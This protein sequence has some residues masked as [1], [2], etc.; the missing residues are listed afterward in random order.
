MLGVA[1]VSLIHALR[2]PSV[3]VG[4]LGAAFALV[5][6]A[7]SSASAAAPANDNVASAQTIPAAGGSFSA[8]NVDATAEAGEPHS[9]DFLDRPRATIW[10]R[11]TPTSDGEVTFDACAGADFHMVMVLYDK[12][13]EPVPPFTNLEDLGSI[14]EDLEPT[15]GCSN[16]YGAAGVFRPTPARTYYLQITGFAGTAGEQSAFTLKVSQAPGTV[17]PG[18]PPPPAPKKKKKGA[19]KKCKKAKKSVASAAKKKKCKR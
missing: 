1:E 9:I 18:A 12:I 17:A 3:L 19:K 13:G 14:G 7:A 8:T 16:E 2:R 6:V 10:Y 15:A 5:L 11:W 4:A